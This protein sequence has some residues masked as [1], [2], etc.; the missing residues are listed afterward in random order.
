MVHLLTSNRPRGLPS[1]LLFLFLGFSDPAAGAAS[2]LRLTERTRIDPVPAENDKLPTT[3]E[4]AVT[5][6]WGENRMI[7]QSSG[8]IVLFDFDASREQRY[9]PA[10]GTASD[11]SLYARF[12]FRFIE[13]RNRQKIGGAFASAGIDDNPFGSVLLLEHD[14]A[15]EMSAP[16]RFEAKTADGVETWSLDGR[17][18]AEISSEGLPA[19]PRDLDHFIRFLVCAHPIHPDLLRELK[20]RDTLPRR[21]TIHRYGLPAS[22]HHLE[23]ESLETGTVLPKLPSLPPGEVPRGLEVAL[24]A[25]RSL[26]PEAWQSWLETTSLRAEA[27]FREKKGLEAALLTFTRQCADGDG[28]A[29]SR[30][31]RK[32]REAFQR[33]PQLQQLVASTGPDS[34]EAAEKAVATLLALEAM[35]GA[36]RPMIQ[37]F[38][39]NNL[40]ALGRQDEAIALFH[41]ALAEAP[42]IAGAW[43]D[44]G[45]AYLK[46]YETGKA[47]LCWD[48]GRRLAP[49]HPF[50]ADIE[51]FEARV[52][53][54][55]PAVFPP[56]DEP[57]AGQ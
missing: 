38:R 1:V 14:F 29:A 49:E 10:E 35:A 5:V 43:K 42:G 15:I 52:R 8:E 27:G 24:E 47:W 44:L 31:L 54:A 18:V 40:S 57:G 9:R 50:W 21:L 37:I 33:D 30:R 46:G 17:P 3:T 51:E 22:V 56:E 7:I 4:D 41:A 11:L 23:L 32:H 34:R 2:A 36:G 19:T 39:A 6:F 48:A 16:G 13:F 55:F 20:G 28:Q 53:A 12:G 26:S 45:D 25:V